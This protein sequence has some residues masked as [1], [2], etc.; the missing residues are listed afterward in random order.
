VAAP[1][2]FL[3]AK[4][5]QAIYRGKCD[6]ITIQGP[7]T[8]REKPPAQKQRQTMEKTGRRTME[9]GGNSGAG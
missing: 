8:A 6:G 2:V 1:L 4:K 5:I 7:E 3:A 9:T